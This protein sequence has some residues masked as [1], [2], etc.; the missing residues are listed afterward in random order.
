MTGLG[1]FV[2][3]ALASLVGLG[4]TMTV[5][6]LRPARASLGELLRKLDA[7]PDRPTARVV[8]PPWARPLLNKFAVPRTELALLNRSMDSYIAVKVACVL[9]GLALPLLMSL[10]LWA[11]RINL[12]LYVPAGASLIGAAVFWFVVDADIRYKARTARREAAYAICSYLDLVAL[13][14]AAGRGAVAALERPAD[15]GTGWVF[16]KLRAAMAQARWEQRA[17][18]DALREVGDE[19]NVPVLGDVG[20]VMQLSGET[21]TQAYQTLRSLAEGLRVSIIAE[22]Q[23]RANSD[24][25]V[26]SVPSTALVIVLFAMGAYPMLARLIAS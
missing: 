1:V 13:E 21:G 18:W 5:A 10:L 3:V 15:I 17:P 8:A 16:D 24:T 4:V 19:L 14:R 23:T 20:A 22:E 25:T 6:G 26:L 7:Q 9:L 11:A 12:P 2:V